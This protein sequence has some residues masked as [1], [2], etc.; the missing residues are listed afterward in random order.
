MA[1]GD[2]LVLP[3]WFVKNYLFD[4]NYRC[5]NTKKWL[6]N[7]LIATLWLIMASIS[8]TTTNQS[9][10]RTIVSLGFEVLG[11]YAHQLANMGMIFVL[12]QYLTSQL[13]HARTFRSLTH[14]SQNLLRPLKSESGHRSQWD[15]LFILC[16]ILFMTFTVGLAAYSTFVIY[17]TDWWLIVYK[18]TIGAICGRAGSSAMKLLICNCLFLRRTCQTLN[19][20]TSKFRNELISAN[21]H[22]K[23]TIT[24]V[25]LIHELQSVCIELAHHN[26]YWKKV[27]F[28]VVSSSIPMTTTGTFVVLQIKSGLLAV[29]GI[30]IATQMVITASM[31]LLMPAN[32]ESKL[33]KCYPLMSQLMRYRSINWTLKLKLLRLVKQFDNQ[34]SF[35]SWDTNKLDYMDYYEVSVIMERN[36]KKIN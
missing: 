26:L 19:E 27:I 13:V 9:L 1:N 8:L 34:I 11:E 17:G 5:V 4:A 10:V 32:V 6:A 33:R 15:Q 31:V 25:S 28:I 21:C 24:I 23:K 20:K 12:I 30:L 3:N 35:T 2:E 16:D 18:M 14:T 29:I 7:V 22:K 36:S